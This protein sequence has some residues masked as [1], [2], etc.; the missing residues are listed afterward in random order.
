MGAQIAAALGM[1]LG[2]A[3]AEAAVIRVVL[4]TDYAHPGLECPRPASG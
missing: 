3:G 1:V 2:V 4:G